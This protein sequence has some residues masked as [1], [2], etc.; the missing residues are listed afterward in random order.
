MKRSSFSRSI[1][2]VIVTAL[3]AGTVAK[4]FA[5]TNQAPLIFQTNYDQTTTARATASSRG[6]LVEWTS[7]FENRI[8]GF[9]VFRIAGAQRVK[10]NPGLI[11][12]PTMV[13]SSR[14]QSFAWYDPA[15]TLDSTYEVESIDLRGESS[16]PTTMT[17]DAAATL[18]AY[19]Q[20]PLLAD[21]GRGKTYQTSSPEWNDAE[22][23][24]S[25]EIIADA[26]ATLLQQWF[27]A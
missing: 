10:L 22:T 16:A 7:Q 23:E 6:V 2:F 18:P 1:A 9:N 26:S 4:L 21:V 17:P 13:F 24:R 12:G 20:T 5:F 19:R 8:L 3:F 15:G 27:I 11:A 25:S 14:Q